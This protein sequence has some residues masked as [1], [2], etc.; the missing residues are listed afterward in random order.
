[1][2]SLILA[3]ALLLF[4]TAGAQAS[5]QLKIAVTPAS[6]TLTAAESEGF[7]VTVSGS[8]SKHADMAVFYQLN[9]QKS[10]APT[11]GK[12][13]TRKGDSQ[14]EPV[15][16]TPSHPQHFPSNPS[17]FHGSFNW[18]GEL[19][20]FSGQAPA[21]TYLMCG[22]LAREDSSGKPLLKASAKFTLTS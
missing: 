21:G 19:K 22:Y 20:V 6:L 10:C 18:Y 13:M 14:F 15:P 9:A 7:A 8:S 16:A 11:A 5:E 4:G 1:M 12:E 3:M 2:R 17:N